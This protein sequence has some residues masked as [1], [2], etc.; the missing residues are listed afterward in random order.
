ME[1][2]RRIFDGMDSAQSKWARRIMLWLSGS[3]SPLTLG[4]LAEA[5]AMNLD[6]FSIN[7][8]D[9]LFDPINILEICKSL[10]TVHDEQGVPNSTYLS[11]A[12]ASVRQYLATTEAGQF[13]LPSKYVDYTLALACLKFSISDESVS[14]L[15]DVDK[16]TTDSRSESY[17]RLRFLG[18][19]TTAALH[20]ISSK[21]LEMKIQPTFLKV[22]EDPV[23]RRNYNLNLTVISAWG[24]AY[25]ALYPKVATVELNSRSYNGLRA[26]YIDPSL[27]VVCSSAGL[28]LSQLCLD[29][30]RADVDIEYLNDKLWTPICYLTALKE[31]EC[32]NEILRKNES[33]P[34]KPGHGIREALCPE[35]RWLRTAGSALLTA[36]ADHNHDRAD[37]LL[38][39]ISSP[40]EFSTGERSHYFGFQAKLFRLVA[41]LAGEDG[42]L[43]I[44]KQLMKVLK[45]CIH[46]TETERFV[47]MLHAL[48]GCVKLEHLACIAAILEL[49]YMCPIHEIAAWRLDRCA[50]LEFFGSLVSVNSVWEIHFNPELS[51][52][53][54]ESD[55][56][57][58]SYP[59]AAA[60][61]NLGASMNSKA[62]TKS[63]HSVLDDTEA[64]LKHLKEK[65]TP[66]DT[67]VAPVAQKRRRWDVTVR[68]DFTFGSHRTFAESLLCG[69][70]IA[71]RQTLLDLA[72]F[73]AIERTLDPNVVE[74]LLVAGADPNA[75][76]TVDAHFENGEDDHVISQD[77][78]S[79]NGLGELSL[80]YTNQ[81]SLVQIW[82]PL[83]A[84]CYDFRWQWQQ[85]I[86][87]MLLKRGANPRWTAKGVIRSPM[88]ATS[89]S[90]TAS[91]VGSPLLA[92]AS[93]RSGILGS[94]PEPLFER[95]EKAGALVDINVFVSSDEFGTP[96]IAASALGKHK[97][98][99]Q[100]LDHGAH[101]D[102][103]GHS[104]VDWR[105]PALAAIYG[106]HE[107][108][109]LQ[110]LEKEGYATLSRMPRIW[111]KAFIVACANACSD[112]SSSWNLLVQNLLN[113]GVNVNESAVMDTEIG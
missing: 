74:A 71:T 2:Y 19:C 61:I 9:R 14:F 13:Y 84:V 3:R 97:L 101:P 102:L 8:A 28:G 65:E 96:L 32:V 11:L 12:H 23:L 15:K 56:H 95:L 107:D 10:V 5:V 77:D 6:D 91:R 73:R 59:R 47:T 24:H 72:L 1:T 66:V 63:C 113:R 34:A 30:V 53:L 31:N 44:L 60:R 33:R 112:E 99:N 41:F 108:I 38:T 92:I 43:R 85:P 70:P 45:D 51:L 49:S 103:E 93:G 89:S 69:V 57:V 18:Y 86:I 106:G 83:M 29:F 67:F 35:N 39:A 78:I 55:H 80:T 36:I 98:V 16:E 20:H 46:M 22:F 94:N 26:D 87:E 100:L 76:R 75:E 104:D 27:S 105:L 42:N 40:V 7:D 111:G 109:A 58:L 64:Y 21:D 37:E 79:P 17:H 52:V 81:S 25:T 110:I 50:S 90:D 82:T 4:M 54:T 68:I 88:F 48:A 62:P